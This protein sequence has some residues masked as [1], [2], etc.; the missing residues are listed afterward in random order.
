MA[1]IHEEEDRDADV[2]GQE[3]TRRP[4]LREEHRESIDQTEE[5]EHEHGNV[6]TVGLYPASVRDFDALCRGSFAEPEVDDTA[7]DPGCHAP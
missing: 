3:G 4:V 6:C 7:T 2:S 5:R 1:E